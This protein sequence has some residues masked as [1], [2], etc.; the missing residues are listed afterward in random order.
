MGSEL[1]SY[2][3]EKIRA[4]QRI[5]GGKM[6]YIECTDEKTLVSFYENNGYHIISHRKSNE[7]DLLQMIKYLR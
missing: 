2:A 1:I 3:E 4:T 6:V 5:I 7:G